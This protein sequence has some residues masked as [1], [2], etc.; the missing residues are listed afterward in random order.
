[1]KSFTRTRGVRP[2]NR[3]HRLPR[4][5][6]GVA[7]AAAVIA[8]GAPGVANA[9]SGTLNVSVTATFS[10]LSP[11]PYSSGDELWGLLY[12]TPLDLSRTTPEPALAASWTMASNNRSLT[13]KLRPDLKFSDGTP[14]NAAAI[15]WNINWEK[16]AANGAHTAAVYQ[17]VTA[18]AVNETTVRLRFTRAVPA[19]YAALAE[20]PIVKPNAPTS[21]VASGPFEVSSYVPGTS[22]TVSANPH[23]YEPGAPHVEKVV[24]TDYQVPTTAELALKDGTIQFDSEVQGSIVPSLRSNGDIIFN[25]PSKSFF[26]LL[27]NTKTAALHSEKVREALSLAF[28][29]AEFVQTALQGYGLPLYSIFAPA[30]APYYSKAADSGSYDL[31]EAKALLKS[32][33]VTSLTLSVDTPSIFPQ[34]TFLPV[35]Q[36]ALASI[37]V[38]LKIDQLDLASWEQLVTEG[39]FPDLVAEVYGDPDYDPQLFL[40]NNTF[41]PSGNV[42]GFS[43]PKYTKLINAAA[44]EVDTAKRIADYQALAAYVKQESFVIPLATEHTFGAYTPS[45]TDVEPGYG[46]FPVWQTIRVK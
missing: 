18:K 42:E 19:I 45:V 39:G 5:A 46:G 17:Y 8:A 13:L 29:R 21:G 9:A 22:L 7:A 12:S 28:N 1:M 37:G 27:L 32:A 14:L 41:E 31:A 44:H 40:G 23:Y 20:T 4:V 38:T 15:V 3:F 35:Y 26:A 6:G 36:Q 24:M 2:R 30:A 16:E 11:L 33:G 43:S 10:T 34:A 25:A